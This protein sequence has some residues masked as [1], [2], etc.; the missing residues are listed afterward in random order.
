MSSVEFIGP[1]K[2]LSTELEPYIKNPELIPN[3]V[4]I[5]FVYEEIQKAVE[6]LFEIPPEKPINSKSMLIF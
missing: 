3:Q 2:T 6:R 5:G 4:E 1:T